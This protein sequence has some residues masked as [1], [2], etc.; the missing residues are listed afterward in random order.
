[1]S[2]DSKKYLDSISKQSV[3]YRLEDSERKFSN[4]DLNQVMLKK[5]KKKER[6]IKDSLQKYSALST[7]ENENKSPKSHKRELT[8]SSKSPERNTTE[9]YAKTANILNLDSK[10]D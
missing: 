4:N 5:I 9:Y 7:F 1:M 10:F 3:K 8:R 6:K 2:D